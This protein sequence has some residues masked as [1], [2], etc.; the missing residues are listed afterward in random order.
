LKEV[1]KISSD[2]NLL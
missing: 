2:N 1:T